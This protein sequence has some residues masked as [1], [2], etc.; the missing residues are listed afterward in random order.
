APRRGRSGRLVESVFALGTAASVAWLAAVYRSAP[1]ARAGIARIPAWSAS[2]A[3]PLCAAAVAAVL[4]GGAFLGRP[5]AA[6]R[7]AGDR[8][9]P[10]RSRRIFR[11]LV[12]RRGRKR[13]RPAPLCAPATGGA[14]RSPVRP[15]APPAP[16]SL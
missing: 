3:L 4:M 14:V 13:A 5:R 2:H 6:G 12:P 16:P 7:P 15:P 1:A 9:G 8:A 11:L 10:R